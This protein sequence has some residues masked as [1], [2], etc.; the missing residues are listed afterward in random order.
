VRG[1]LLDEM[2]AVRAAKQ[3][4]DQHAC[5]QPGILLCHQLQRAIQMILIYP[6]QPLRA[7]D[8]RY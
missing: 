3:A 4:Q 6:H 5:L 7:V 2:E 8:A 1:L